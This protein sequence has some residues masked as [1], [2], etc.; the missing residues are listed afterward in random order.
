MKATPFRASRRMTSATPDLPAD[1]P[2]LF[3][4][5]ITCATT[6]LL[7]RKASAIPRWPIHKSLI[8]KH[9]PRCGSRSSLEFCSRGIYQIQVLGGWPAEIRHP[10]AAKESE[11]AIDSWKATS[12]ACSLL[13]WQPHPFQ[14]LEIEIDCISVSGVTLLPSPGCGATVATG[15]GLPLPSGSAFELSLRRGGCCGIDRPPA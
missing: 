3:N 1:M 11:P 6:R 5:N 14:Q 2:Y 12:R 15:Q 7:F 9:V 8:Q 10:R 13:C 4:G